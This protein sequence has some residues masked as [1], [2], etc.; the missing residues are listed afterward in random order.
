M[1]SSNIKVSTDEAGKNEASEKN[2]NGENEASIT[3]KVDEPKSNDKPRAERVETFI[4]SRC[5]VT[6][7]DVEGICE[8]MKG[9]G[10]S[11]DKTKQTSWG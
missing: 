2:L 4:C 9:H 6:T 1:E 5:I 3:D 10:V 8:H 7:N 11:E